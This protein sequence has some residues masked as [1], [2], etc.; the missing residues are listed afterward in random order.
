V[1]VRPIST[2]QISDGQALI[3]SGLTPGEKV[4]V[5]G[6]YRLQAG[7]LVRELTGEEAATANLQSSVEQQIP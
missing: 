4:V 5:D 2:S 6:Q 7:T 1:L 3:E